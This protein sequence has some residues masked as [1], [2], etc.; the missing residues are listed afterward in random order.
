MIATFSL[1]KKIDLKVDLS[2]YKN[3]I[4]QIAIRYL[5][6]DLDSNND[7]SGAGGFWDLANNI[8]SWDF[9]FLDEMVFK[10]KEIDMVNL[11]EFIDFIYIKLKEYAVKIL[12]ETL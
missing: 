4:K 8:I 3:E 11:D 7:E 2:K 1:N 6:G 12:K 9:S 5:K 10:E